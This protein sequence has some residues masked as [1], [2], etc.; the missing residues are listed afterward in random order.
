MV[1]PYSF[2]ARLRYRVGLFKLEVLAILFKPSR[3]LMDYTVNYTLNILGTEKALTSIASVNQGIGRLVETS[4]RLKRSFTELNRILNRTS[5]WALR[6]NTASAEKSVA[7]LQERVNALKSS[8]ASVA[9]IGGKGTKPAATNA[10]SATTIVTPISS[11]ERRLASTGQSKPYT[12]QSKFYKHNGAIYYRGPQMPSER[13]FGAG[14]TW[15]KTTIPTKVLDRTEW[16]RYNKLLEKQERVRRLS[17]RAAGNKV[18]QQRLDKLAASYQG[19]MNQFTSG[20]VTT[21]GVGV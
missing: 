4:N 21:L 10:K 8:M 20:Y 13:M 7:R 17:E 15:T 18:Q 11:K 1:F 12:P 14:V 3:I 19:R 2:Y 9:A 6:I 5:G 16:A